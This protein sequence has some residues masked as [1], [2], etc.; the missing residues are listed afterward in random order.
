MGKGTKVILFLLVAIV[1]L[2]LNPIEIFT[3]MR[4]KSEVDR[5]LSDPAVMEELF[6]GEIEDIEHI[7]GK[8]YSVE[9]NGSIFV[10]LVEKKNGRTQFDIFEEI[11]K[12]N[13]GQGY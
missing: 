13:Q 2:L 11:R 1:L 12:V 4:T 3:E 7:G 6:D 9:A 5:L 8:T 10:I